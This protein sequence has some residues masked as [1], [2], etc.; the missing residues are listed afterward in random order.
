L[1]TSVVQQLIVTDMGSSKE[2]LDVIEQP[3]EEGQ[4]VEKESND[5]GVPL[6]Y[7]GTASDKRDMH[8]MGKKQ[9]LR[10]GADHTSTLYRRS[11]GIHLA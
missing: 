7:R 1:L 5:E 10:V 11:N 9:V 2:D 4:S 6:R 8:I 3:V